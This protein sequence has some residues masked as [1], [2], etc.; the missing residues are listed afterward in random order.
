[1][2]VREY[3]VY[4]GQNYVGSFVVNEETGKAKA[5]D[6]TGRLIGAF[7][8]Y[9][10]ARKAVSITYC[11]EVERKAATEEA[12]K[13]INRPDVEFASGLPVELASGWKRR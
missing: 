10:A 11:Q 2:S 5:L 4:E 13:R 9:D 3:T 6:A 8:G 7:D 1:M 12:L